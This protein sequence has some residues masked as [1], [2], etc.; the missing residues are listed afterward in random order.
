[1]IV[2]NMVTRASVKV[3]AP[4]NHEV[5]ADL[6]AIGIDGGMVSLQF[7][8]KPWSVEGKPIETPAF[9]KPL[10]FKTQVYQL[11]DSH[12]F[13]VPYVGSCNGNMVL[14]IACDDDDNCTDAIDAIFEEVKTVLN[15]HYFFFEGVR[16]DL[17]ESLEV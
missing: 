15:Y 6:S 10:D 5:K 9:H 8:M 7:L 2:H 14:L 3:N 16:K 13:P 1:M 17:I 11:L 4:F 12:F